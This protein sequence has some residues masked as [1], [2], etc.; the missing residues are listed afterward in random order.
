MSV[1][2][3][4]PISTTPARESVLRDML[5]AINIATLKILLTR[6]T[7]TVEARDN[8][9]ANLN[10]A[11]EPAPREEQNVETTCASAVM[12]TLTA[13]KTATTTEIATAPASQIGILVTRLASLDTIT[14]ISSMAVIINT[15]M[16]HALKKVPL[17]NSMNIVMT[18]ISVSG[19]VMDVLLKKTAPA[20]Q[21][22][23]P[24]SLHHR[25]QQPLLPLW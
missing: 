14:A 6:T 16:K 11:T 18:A 12:M 20:P 1:M 24:A 9:L 10:N 3:S 23:S 21:I 22:P 13:G 7:G 15:A 25:Q 5:R 17:T 4:V 19:L 8:A 2:E